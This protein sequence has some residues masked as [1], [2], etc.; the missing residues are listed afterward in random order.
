MSWQ[1]EYAEGVWLPQVGWWLDARHA[2]ERSFVSHAHFDHLA[3]HREILCSPGT[4]R[5][6][7]ARMPGDRREHILPF[8]QTE[9]LTPEVAV[10]LHPAGHIHGSAQCLLEHPERGRLLYTG[11]FKLRRGRAA[12]P[13]ATPRADVLVMETTFGR[14][15][16]RFPPT[17]EVLAALTGFCLAALDDGETPVLFAYSLG[18]SQELLWALAEHGLPVMLHPQTRRMTDV[19]AELGLEVP[20]HREYAAG[21]VRGHVVLCPPQSRT[22]PFLRRLGPCRTAVVTGW[23][24]DPGAIHR[25]QCDAA[26]PL[27]DHADFDDLLRFVEQVNPQRVYTL[28]GFARDFAATLRERGIEAWALSEENQLD[29]GLGPAASAL[30]GT[31]AANPAKTTARSPQP[32]TDLAAGDPLAFARF[33]ALADRIAAQPRRHAKVALLGYYL[34]ALPPSAAAIAARCACARTG[35]AGSEGQT[36]VGWALLRRALLERTGLTEAQYRAGFQ[37]F[38]DAGDAAEAALRTRDPGGID[39]G[40]TLPALEAGCLALATARGPAAKLAQVQTLLTQLGPTEAKYLI[41]LLL[42]DLRIGLKEGLVEDAIAQAWAQ[43][44][45]AVREAHLLAGDLGEVAAHAAAGKLGAIGL[46]PF[47]PLRFMLATPAADPTEILTRLGPPIWLEEKYDG[48]RC[49]V[50][51]R[52]DRVELYSRDLKLLTAQF[53]ELAR[54]AA[55]LPEDFIGDAELL[56]WRDGR[57]LPFAEL[58]RRLGRRG[59]DLFLGAEIPVS[60][61]FYDLLWHAGQP[62]IAEPL[63]ERRRRLEALLAGSRAPAL[64]LAPVRTAGTAAEI[65]AAFL[66]A[67]RRGNEGLMAKDPA[68]PYSPGRRGQAWLK[69]KRAGATLDVVVV[70]VEQGHGKRRDVL[71]DYTFA[72]REEA[73]GRLLV[74]GKAYTGLTDAEIARLTDHFLATTTAVRGRRREVL[75]Q[76][77][78]EIAFDSIQASPRH[79][80]GLALRFPR[81]VRLRPDKT[82][83]EIDT[84]A[85]CRRL[86]EVRFD[87]GETNAVDPV[88]PVPQPP[89]MNAAPAA[90]AGVCEA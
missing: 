85:H 69:L 36:G 23:A 48:I 67:R 78:L 83:A 26:F 24:L 59:D 82:P 77:V 31:P 46:R 71:S 30:E 55:T 74:L 72:I 5:L 14:P 79:D 86:A 65:E 34:A 45:A 25:H 37:R 15:Q 62:L 35:P 50:H 61:S 11:D 29:L 81:I 6:M 18:K 75:P 43:P 20:P 22:S 70:A 44:A 17:S 76:V 4:A 8:G 27:S 7:R 53:P 12:E 1:V 9:P 88:G 42:G 84:L 39:R 58:Q 32:S 87:P 68:S 19:Y 66:A 90:T 64:Q 16:Y 41:K 60:L 63:R 49:Q 28:H 10:S 33:A 56:A 80:S 51:R 52:G 57:A 21:E 89:P 2:R 54:A 40:L 47:Q 38:P 13:C 3:L 73:T